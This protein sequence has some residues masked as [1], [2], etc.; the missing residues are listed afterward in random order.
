MRIAIAFYGITRSLSFTA[1]SIQK[2]IIEPAKLE[3]ETTVFCHFF[4]QKYIDNPRTQ[5]VGELNIN[6]WKLLNADT[7]I[8]EDISNE[9]EEYYLSALLPY[10]NAWED[11]G[12]SLRNILRQL[13]SLERVTHAIESKG[14]FDLIIYARP[15]MLFHDA[16]PIS[17]WK[18]TVDSESVV[19]PSWQWSGGLND[20]FSACGRLAYKAYGLRISKAIDFC[21]KNK[22]PLHSERLLMFALM[23]G[24]VKL[25]TTFVRASRVRSNGIH[26]HESFHKVKIAKRI[27]AYIYC[28]IYTWFVRLFLSN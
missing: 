16:L 27:E 25:K 14:D 28:N 21:F 19:I 22:R 15:D 23:H 13:I 8:I 4:E 10:G 12:Q 11:T 24:A 1:Q 6:E 2:N 18:K 3:G 20:R 5:E 26:A 9:L 17:L 7:V